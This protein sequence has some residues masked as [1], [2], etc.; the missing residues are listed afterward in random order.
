[1]SGSTRISRRSFLR[2]STLFGAVVG[3]TS[4]SLPGPLQ[5]RTRLTFYAF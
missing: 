2:K 1:M 3:G 4:I 5:A